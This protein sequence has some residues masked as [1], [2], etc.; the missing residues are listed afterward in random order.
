MGG[1]PEAPDV[2]A[3]LPLSAESSH[4][5]RSLLPAKYA[6]ICGTRQ[7]HPGDVI[8]R[9]EFLLIAAS[10]AMVWQVPTAAQEP[11]RIYRLGYLVAAPREAPITS[12]FVMSYGALVLSQG[13]TGSGERA[14]KPSPT[15]KIR[16]IKRDK[17]LGRTRGW[18]DASTTCCLR[19]L[20]GDARVIT[21]ARGHLFVVTIQQGNRQRGRAEPG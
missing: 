12:R 15:A 6:I 3:E 17:P 19:R 11:G 4:L 20:W 7:N 21:G 9:R 8:Q 10:A 2:A 18:A 16:C 14:G 1:K 13:K 5:L